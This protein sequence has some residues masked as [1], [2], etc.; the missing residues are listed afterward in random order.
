MHA[1]TTWLFINPE[2]AWRLR[3]RIQFNPKTFPQWTNHL[4]L[5]MKFMRRGAKLQTFKI[6]SMS[7]SEKQLFLKRGEIACKNRQDFIT[8]TGFAWLNF[9]SGK[10]TQA[11]DIS[12]N[13]LIKFVPPRSNPFQF[14]TRGCELINREEL[15]WTFAIRFTIGFGGRGVCKLA[16]EPPILRFMKRIILHS[17]YALPCDDSA[18]YFAWEWAPL[19]ACRGFFCSKPG[20]SWEWQLTASDSFPPKTKQNSANPGNQMQQNG[21]RALLRRRL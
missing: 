16:S 20:Q 4:R 6:P 13:I 15:S 10:L 7:K 3:V 2:R 5:T 11:G 14:T 9:I 21:Y 17:H 1:F 18:A 8:L 19:C 12:Q